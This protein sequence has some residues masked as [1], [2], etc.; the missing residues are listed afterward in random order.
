MKA[1]NQKEVPRLTRWEAENGEVCKRGVHALN[2]IL[3]DTIALRE[4]YRAHHPEA[5]GRFPLH[6]LYGKHYVE[7]AALADELAERIQTLGGASVAMASN[8]ANLPM[9]RDGVS[10]ELSRLLEGHE[11]LLR[12]S[13]EAAVEAQD[14]GDDGTNDL[15][16]SKV[17]LTNEVEVWYLAQHLVRLQSEES[18]GDPVAASTGL[19]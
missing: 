5:S 19:P 18:G 6:E 2:Q 7:Q 8:I 11:G 4:L 9:G 1:D 10:D 14:Q 3:A 16:V 17:I 12:L 15:L 13:H